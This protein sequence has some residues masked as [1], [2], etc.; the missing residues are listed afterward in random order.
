MTATLDD[1]AELEEIRLN[2]RCGPLFDLFLRFE[3]ALA[4]LAIDRLDITDDD[5][6]A[7]AVVMAGTGTDSGAA[8]AYLMRHIKTERMLRRL[9][10]VAM[11]TFESRAASG[12]EPVMMSMAEIAEFGRLRGGST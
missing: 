9:C 4:R 10:C 5:A 8:F 12:M 7:F 11:A 1:G 3:K 6:E 2:E